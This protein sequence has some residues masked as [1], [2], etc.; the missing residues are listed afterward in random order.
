MSV[1]AALVLPLF[2]F[3]V[4]NILFFLDAVFVQSMVDAALEQAGGEIAEYAYF[5]KNAAAELSPKEEEESDGTAVMRGTA[6]SKIFSETFVRE[7]CAAFLREV[8]GTENINGNFWTLSGGLDSLSFLR[9]EIMVGNENIK[10]TADYC[11]TPILKIPGMPPLHLQSEY[12][13]HAW[14]GYTNDGLGGEERKNTVYITDSG[15]VY[16]R[17][18]DCTY[19]RPSTRS[20][21]AGQIGSARNRNG[22]KYYP[23]EM[24]RPGKSGV[25]YITNDGNRYHNSV[26]CSAL[27]RAVREISV[28]DAERAM[29]ACSK[30]GS[31]HD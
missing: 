9:S 6:V 25:L 19:L 20:V 17:S 22:A 2:L 1:E 21:A 4:V 16:H 27:K 12:F 31:R 30:C 7:R 13:T 5:Y 24:C 14:T 23:C 29:R 11:L 15:S 3:F 10:L 28:E 26:S 8:F 18:R